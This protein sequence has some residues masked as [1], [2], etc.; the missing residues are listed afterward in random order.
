MSTP[1]NQERQKRKLLNAISRRS[2]AKEC[3]ISANL[4]DKEIRRFL[5]S[6]S[7]QSATLFDIR[8][9]QFGSL[10]ATEQWAASQQEPIVARRLDRLSTDTVDWRPKKRTTT[11]F[12]KICRLSDNLKMWHRM[13]KELV[14]A[15]HQPKEHIGDWKGRGR[16]WQVKKIAA[17]INSNEQFIVVADVCR[18]FPS[19][20]LDAIYEL[21]YL[22]EAL[23]RRAIDSRSLRFSRGWIGSCK[24]DTP[25]HACDNLEMD[26]VGLLEGSP[27]SNA[28]FSVLMD[29]LPDHLDKDIKCFVYC[30]NIV[31]VALNKARAQCAANALGRYFTAHQAGPFEITSEIW[32]AKDGIDHLGYWIH[33]R[34]DE[35]VVS[36]SNKS[37]E[38]LLMR[39]DGDEETRS[40]TRRWLNASFAALS[41]KEARVWNEVVGDIVG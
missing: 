38:R 31:L 34:A 9:K 14:E 27:A 12:R 35:T 40:D 6:H 33:R 1:A 37:W 21:N 23:V 22:P 36:I 28:I 25:L 39:L 20:N 29:D 19:V 26:P 30:D 32:R 24:W 15:Q 7:V 2:L 16:D 41:E 3:K 10:E 11:G 5:Q 17:S 4:R 8:R 13:A 18:A